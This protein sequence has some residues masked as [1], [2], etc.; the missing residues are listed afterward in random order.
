M[1]T[2]EEIE[3]KARSCAMYYHKARD[4]TNQKKRFITIILSWKFLFSYRDFQEQA[5]Y[6]RYDAYST[7]QATGYPNKTYSPT[8][9]PNSLAYSYAHSFYYT[10]DALRP[11]TAPLPPAPESLRA[12][13]R[14][15]SGKRPPPKRG[16]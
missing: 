5:E 7:H 15:T 10:D 12:N 6:D 16:Y 1:D 14:I 8:P 13:P 4:L 2:N 9:N 11:R 3:M